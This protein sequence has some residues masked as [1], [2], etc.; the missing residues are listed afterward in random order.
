MALGARR[1]V[2][3]GMIV[4]DGM[5]PVLAGSLIGLAGSMGIT[6]LMKR[7]LFGV[8]P[9]DAATYMAASVVLAAVA[10]CACCIPACRAVRVDP[11][12][13]LRDE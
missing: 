10:I 8:Q 9:W 7:L 12:V 11:L 2:L 3:F 5:R 4:R 13:A 6:G 1:S